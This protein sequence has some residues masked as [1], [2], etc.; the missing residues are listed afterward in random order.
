MKANVNL[1]IRDAYETAIE[2]IQDW[3]HGQTWYLFDDE[4]AIVYEPGHSPSGFVATVKTMGEF[5]AAAEWCNKC[6]EAEVSE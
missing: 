4:S 5:H 6:R 3:C 2:E 1:D